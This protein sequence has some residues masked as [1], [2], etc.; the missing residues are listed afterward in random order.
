M[1]E[2]TKEATA[3]GSSAGQ[4]YYNTSKNDALGTLLFRFL[5]PE[6][7]LTSAGIDNHSMGTF[8]KELVRKFNEQNNEKA[9]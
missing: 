9:N 3:L 7:G 5:D 8:F 1:L 2:L 4:L 6:I